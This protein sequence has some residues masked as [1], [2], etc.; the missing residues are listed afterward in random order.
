[1]ER[2]AALVETLRKKTGGR[3]FHDVICACA[4]PH[5]QRWMLQCFNTEGDATAACFGGTRELVDGVD[6]DVHHYRQARTVG[7]SGCSTRCMETVLRWLDDGT[8]ALRG[9]TS[10]ELFTLES[11]PAEFFTTDAGGLK[12]MLYP[13]GRD[14]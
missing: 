1:M 8:L 4:D 12:P 3:L 10:P 5:A 11:D 2:E 6:M 9:F 13:W 14:S 7:S